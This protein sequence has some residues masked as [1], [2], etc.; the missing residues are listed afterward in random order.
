LE[1]FKHFGSLIVHYLGNV[2]VPFEITRFGDFL[3]LW[4]L[5]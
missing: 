3:V 4:K 2:L 5:L 1:L